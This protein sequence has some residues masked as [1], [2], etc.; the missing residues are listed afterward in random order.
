MPLHELSLDDLRLYARIADFGSLS[1][2][3]R[4]ANLAVSQVS[5]ALRRVE[6]ACGVQLVRRSTHGISLTPEGITVHQHVQRLLDEADAL[7]S[8]LDAARGGVS[9]LVRVSMSAV[10]AEHLLDAQAYGW[11]R[12][13]EFFGET[14]S[15]TERGRAEN[16][17]QL[18]AELDGVGGRPA[19]VEAHRQFVVLNG[20]HGVACTNWQLRPTRYDRFAPNDHTDADW[21]VAVLIELERLDNQLQQVDALLSGVLPRLKGYGRLHREALHRVRLGGHEWLDGPDRASCQIVWMQ[22]HEDLLATLGLAR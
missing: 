18:S 7:Q 20:P 22:L 12:R 17:R 4:E 8:G 16:E 1:A 11:V 6:A 2:T 14:W 5:R 15:M 10:L 21:D 3:A 9:G 19:V 13:H